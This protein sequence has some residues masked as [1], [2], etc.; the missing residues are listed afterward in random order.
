M[1][2]IVEESH[3][4]PVVAL[5]MYVRAGSI[6]EGEFLG[7]GISHFFEH[8]LSGGA[9]Q[10]RSE[11][12]A[13]KLVESIGG[14]VNAYTTT[15]HTCYYI[16][17]LS[18]HFDTALELLSDWV[19]RHKFVENEY[20]RE[21]S[22]ILEEMRNGEAD[23]NRQLHY[24]MQRTMFAVHPTR[25]PVIGERELFMTITQKDLETYY[26][27]MYVPNNIVFVAVGDF[28]ADEVMGKI[29][30]QF[31]D[32][33]ARPTPAQALPAEPRQLSPREAVKEMDVNVAYLL[34]GFR[35]VALSHPDLYPLD[36]LSV[37]LSDGDSS[38][39]ARA[40]REEKR[41]A[42]AVNS[43]S[44]TPSY[45]AG[46]FAVKA[47]CQPDQVEACR[48]AVM[49]EL[50]R[51]K[52]EP[53]TE[54]ELARAKRQIAAGRYFGIQTAQ[55]R[56]ADLGGNMLSA[57]DP[58]F[59]RVYVEAAQRVTAAD[60]MRVAKQYLEAERMCLV[61]VRPPMG[62]A[63]T[64]AEAQSKAGT[65]KKLKLANGVRA[66]VKSE[67]RLPIV[68]ARAVFLAGVRAETEKD[69]GIGRMVAEMLTR[70]T[71]TRSTVEIARI[72]DGMGGGM[73]AGSGNNSLYIEMHCLKEDLDR[74]MEVMADCVINPSF[75][76]EEVEQ[77]RRLA[78]A[79]LKRR[80]DNWRSF[81]SDRFM[82]QFFKL[83]AYRMRP[84]GNEAALKALT[85][86]DLAA[87]HRKY[88]SAGN[89]VISVF[90]D[91]A[92]EKAFALIEKHFG[93]M[94][95]AT[96]FVAPAPSPEPPL[97][98]SRRVN[99]AIQKQNL[100]TVFV[101]YS[102]LKVTDL[103]DRYVMDVIDSLTSGMSLPGGWLHKA[104]R[105]EEKGLVYEVHAYHMAGLDPGY[106]G[107]YAACNPGNV[108][109]V[110][111][112]IHDQMG[113][114]QESP[115]EATE[116]ETAKEMCLAAHA[117]G[118]QTIGEQALRSA[119]D[120][121]YGLGWDAGE[122]YAEGIKAVTVEDVRRVAKQYLQKSLTLVITPPAKGE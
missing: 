50:E 103:K 86:D 32:L 96:D 64:E 89:M 83:S 70:G 43:W 24:L 101:G 42:L 112:I 75:P 108:E 116:L 111:K 51:V 20:Q 9:T 7:A 80:D 59:T 38:R 6:Y 19:V 23:P 1:T 31:A 114:L 99:L 8:L 122:R 72:F 76:P 33:A 39:L 95:A 18:K 47:V 65:V 67:S 73:E 105:G 21:R 5:R 28:K 2:V 100:G 118:D 120:E 60:V 77:A 17:T 40:V 90:G 49:E 30:K 48:A 74:A 91:V 82:E 57:D 16:N 92:E 34:M 13:R 79:S 58:D 25:F 113:R 117:M 109:E 102:G 110:V 29:R 81:L 53:V 104:L 4:A 26:R 84:D 63:K 69:N 66:L 27:R 61:V 68:A 36:M 54:E 93:A 15:D 98:E 88:L 41:L 94:K 62:A 12:E 121:L 37:I 71:K 3:A 115:I 85:R 87:Y 44:H 55:D 14:Q 11:E 56:A 97:A 45:D 46:Q 106:F 35:T 78:L 22:V 107:V 119:L 52:R 10:T